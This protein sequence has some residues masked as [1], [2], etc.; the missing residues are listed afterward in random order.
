MRGVARRVE[1]RDRPAADVERVAVIEDPESLR[2]NG[3]HGS[4]QRGHAFLAVH[5][6]RAAHQARRIRQMLRTA[7][8][9]PHGGVREPGGERAHPARMIQVDVREH[10]VRERV[11]CDAERVERACHRLDGR[12]RT[13]FHQRRLVRGEEICG[14]IALAS[15]HERVDRRDAGRDL[16]RDGF[17]RRESTAGCRWR[18]LACRV[19][20]RWAFPGE[21]PP[22]E[23][24]DPW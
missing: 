9:D 23:V 8:V 12:A 7:F 11:G 24:V 22:K 4:E 18:V 15:S 5:A 3:C 10:D 19:R 16:E 14:R 21:P 17:H 20:G 1:R 2:R 13:R 6:C